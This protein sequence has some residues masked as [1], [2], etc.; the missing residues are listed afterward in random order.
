MAKLFLLLVILST[1]CAYVMAIS[2]QN[3]VASCFNGAIGNRNNNL[4]DG[5]NYYGELSTNYRARPLDFRALGGLPD[6]HPLRITYNGKS[7]L[8]TKGD[9]GAGGRRH[10]KINIHL[11]A[12]KALGFTTCSSFGIRTVTIETEY[13][14]EVESEYESEIHEI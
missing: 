9:V 11:T 10:P 12:A 7:V 14:A 8:A 13:E 1:A 3:V 5:G 2:R 4:N 6:G